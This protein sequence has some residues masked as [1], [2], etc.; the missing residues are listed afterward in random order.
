MQLTIQYAVTNG[1]DSDLEFLEICAQNAPG[2]I[3]EEFQNTEEETHPSGKAAHFE[4]SCWLKTALLGPEVD[5]ALVVIEVAGCDFGQCQLG[6][7]AIPLEISCPPEKNQ[8]L[9]LG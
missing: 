6:V 8:A 2:S 3:L 9:A 4:V 7:M 5:E 1:T